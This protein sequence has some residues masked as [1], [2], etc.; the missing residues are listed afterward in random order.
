MNSLHVIY[1]IS[2]SYQFPIFSGSLGSIREKCKKI[3][4]WKFAHTHLYINGMTIKKMPFV[5]RANHIIYYFVILFFFFAF[6]W[7]VR[8][9][10]PKRTKPS[11]MM[12]EREI[13][14]GLNFV[15]LRNM[16]DAKMMYEWG[17]KEK[18][19]I[20]MFVMVLSYFFTP[21]TSISKFH[22]MSV[23]FCCRLYL[24]RFTISCSFFPRSKTDWLS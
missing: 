7:V 2:V 12:V 1:L 8:L 18:F 20:A 16:Y 14:C 5:W 24:L 23:G 10:A 6:C 17:K 4:T 11:T 15:C 9:E 3:E 13:L 21:F 22:S 19:I